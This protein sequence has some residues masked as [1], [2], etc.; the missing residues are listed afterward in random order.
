MN[1]QIGKLEGLQTSLEPTRAM[2]ETAMQGALK[3]ELPEWLQNQVN[4]DTNQQ[5]EAL[6]RK[7]G[8]AT[9]GRRGEI[10]TQ[11]KMGYI[12]KLL[13]MYDPIAT[14][15]TNTITGLSKDIIGAGQ[16]RMTNTYGLEDAKNKLWT[17][18]LGYREKV[19]EMYGNLSG[20]YGNIAQQRSNLATQR[21]SFADMYNKKRWGEISG[22]SSIGQLYA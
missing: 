20:L 17:Q 13:S 7:F 14:N 18:G 19:P 9:A 6:S 4:L 10:G 11:V 16:T 21:G 2:A 22:V 3:G 8:S 5:I 15:R 1:T 12:P